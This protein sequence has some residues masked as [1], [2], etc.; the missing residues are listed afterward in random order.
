MKVYIIPYNYIYENV[1]ALSTVCVPLPT[2]ITDKTNTKQTHTIINIFI[3]FAIKIINNIKT[4]ILHSFG[5]A[6]IFTL[7]IFIFRQI[8]IA[9]APQNFIKMIEI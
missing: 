5:F 8:A 4:F 1:H 6:Y 7:Y 2:C 9:S 3:K